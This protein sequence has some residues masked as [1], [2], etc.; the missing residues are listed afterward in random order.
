MLLQFSNSFYILW[1]ED[2]YSMKINEYFFSLGAGVKIYNTIIIIF[3]IVFNLK[4]T[5]TYF[6]LKG[7]K[8]H[9]LVYQ[10]HYITYKC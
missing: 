9:C 2:K 4:D 5:L 6:I 8:S 7:L 10:L 1:R 3:N